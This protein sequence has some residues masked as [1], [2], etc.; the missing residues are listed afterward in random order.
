[1][2]GAWAIK[3]GDFE[4]TGGFPN[5]WGWGM[6][7]NTMKWRVDNIKLHINYDE[8]ITDKTKLYFF[9][10][11]QKKERYIGTENARYSKYFPTFSNLNNIKN[12][13]YSANEVDKNIKMINIT[14]FNT[15]EIKYDKQK[16][17][18]KVPPR[19]V[20]ASKIRSMS[21]LI[22]L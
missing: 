5:Y 14:H 21:E 6:E 22:R 9:N 20:Y 15:T 3:G 12:I 16:I 17:K 10:R 7:D 8:F 4:R 1:M 13:K 18:Y 2:G 19:L 11:N